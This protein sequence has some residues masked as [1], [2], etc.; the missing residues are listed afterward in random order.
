[1]ESKRKIDPFRAID[2]AKGNKWLSFLIS[3]LP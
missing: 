3:E 1:M 2:V